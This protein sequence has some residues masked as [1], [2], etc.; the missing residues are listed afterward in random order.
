ML[1][2]WHVEL[3]RLLPAAAQGSAAG[4]LALSVAASARVPARVAPVTA[5]TSDARIADHRG[6]WARAWPSARE[7]AVAAVVV[8]AEVRRMCSRL[9]SLPD[10]WGKDAVRV[11]SVI[12]E[13]SWRSGVP[14]GRTPFSVSASGRTSASWPAAS[15]SDRISTAVRRLTGQLRGP[16]EKR[17]R[18][19]CAWATRARAWHAKLLPETHGK[20]RLL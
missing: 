17:L 5:C 7:Q 12:G 9:G 15:K 13:R 11:M 10:V 20:P 6:R 19:S 18:R 16:P 4:I 8:L 3:A 14:L 1:L 2:R